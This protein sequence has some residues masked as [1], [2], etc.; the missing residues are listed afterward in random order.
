MIPTWMI[1]E[2]ERRRQ[3]REERERPSLRIELPV[4]VQVDREPP[5]RRDA[6]RCL[7]TTRGRCPCRS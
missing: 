3:E 6:D 5:A 4:P 1:E 2:L 7:S